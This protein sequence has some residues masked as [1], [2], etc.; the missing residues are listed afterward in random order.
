VRVGIIQSNYIPWR[1]YFDFI[2]D[3]DVFILFDDVQYTSRD[4]RNRNKLKTREGTEWITVSVRQSRGQLIEEVPIDWSVDWPERHL[5]LLRENY[6]LAPFFDEVSNQ[7]AE[8]LSHRPERLSALNRA[9]IEWG[10]QRLGIVTHL[11]DAS[12]LA[13]RG[14]KTER[15]ISLVEAVGGTVYLSGPSAGA[16][17]EPKAFSSAG[18]ALE[19]KSYDYPAYPQLWGTFEG[20]VSILDLLLNTGTDAR[21]YLKSRT[22]NRE[23]VS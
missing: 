1:G 18:I 2:D 22:P 13:G 5:N 4:W 19:Y 12:T 20:L 16:Y 15:L 6:R 21:Y 10:M 23:F 8:I 11:I 14:Q 9:L 17:I 7:F 3:C